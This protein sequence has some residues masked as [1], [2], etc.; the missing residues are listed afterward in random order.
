MTFAKFCL[1]YQ[2]T[3]PLP[4]RSGEWDGGGGR[5]CGGRRGGAG[6]DDD[7]ILSLIMSGSM[8]PLLYELYLRHLCAFV[9]VCVCGCGACTADTGPRSLLRLCPPPR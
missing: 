2:L 9:R 5:G 7:N 4:A 8:I 6:D 1:R 3:G